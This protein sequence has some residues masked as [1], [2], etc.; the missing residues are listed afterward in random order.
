M[1]SNVGGR[2]KTRN[3]LNPPVCEKRGAGQQDAARIFIMRK[4]DLPEI[5][6]SGRGIVDRVVPRQMTVE[7]WA[8]P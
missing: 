2:F 7:L 4:L 6:P 3:R 1:P 8:P 5:R